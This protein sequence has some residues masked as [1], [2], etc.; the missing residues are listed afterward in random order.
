MTAALFGTG[1]LGG[2]IAQRLLQYGQELWVWNRSPDRCQPLQALGAQQ[3]LRPLEA[4]QQAA[5]SYGSGIAPLI[6]VS[7]CRPWEPSRRSGLW[8]PPSRPRG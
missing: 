3:A 1:L 8:R 6:A 2:A 4:A 5:R 7:P